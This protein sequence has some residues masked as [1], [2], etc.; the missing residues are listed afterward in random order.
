MFAAVAHACGA[1]VALTNRAYD[2][3]KKVG[4]VYM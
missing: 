3:A 2:F 1:S 4:F